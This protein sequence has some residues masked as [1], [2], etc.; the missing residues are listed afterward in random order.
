MMIM[1]QQLI[2]LVLGTLLTQ[3]LIASD[4][5]PNGKPFQ[6]LNNTI[7][8][9]E[10]QVNDLVTSA[11]T[12]DSAILSYT[13]A[14]ELLNNR[15]Q[16]LLVFIE[17][18]A[19]NIE[20]LQ[21][22]MEEN[23]NLI[24]TLQS[25]IN[26]IERQLTLKQNNINGKC[27][28]GEAAVEILDD[29]SLVCSETSTTTS[30]GITMKRYIGYKSIEDEEPMLPG[31]LYHVLSQECPDGYLVTSGSYFTSKYV[32]ILD[33]Y[34]HHIDQKWHWYVQIDPNAYG[35]QYMQVGVNCL[36]VD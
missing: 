17:Q 25:D 34:P 19:D 35:R 5:L 13:Q 9:L 32:Q 2:S 8:N 36:K 22:E 23:S 27:P 4:K 15:N 24:I 3:S 33:S 6:S 1:K 16:E 18:N 20:A 10:S 28:S 12:L 14:I 7:S 21:D 31:N 11:T 30:N 26:S 29:G